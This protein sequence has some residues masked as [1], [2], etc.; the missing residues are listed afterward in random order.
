MLQMVLRLT[1][2]F[3]VV[4]LATSIS[5]HQAGATGLSPQ[6]RSELYDTVERMCKDA[7]SISEY[8]TY[9]GSAGVGVIFKA[10]GGNLS[11]EIEEKK[12]K[13]IEQQFQEFRTNPVVCRFEM[14]EQLTPLFGGDRSDQS[15]IRRDYDFYISETDFL[16]YA[17]PKGIVSA[18]TSGPR[19]S[20]DAYGTYVRLCNISTE[21]LHNVDFEIHFQRGLQYN[22]P[23]NGLSDLNEDEFQY[24]LMTRGS[25]GDASSDLISC[26]RS[27]NICG[28][29]LN[30]IDLPPQSFLGVAVFTGERPREVRVIGVDGR[31]SNHR[32]DI[33]LQEPRH[34]LK[35]D[36]ET[37]PIS[38]GRLASAPSPIQRKIYC[39]C[40]HFNVI[41]EECF[42]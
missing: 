26:R 40:Q 39:T 15:E 17:A 9:K 23:V 8:F 5:L 4:A 11:G 16:Y 29:S 21:A 36:G 18:A 37:T 22:E 34:R 27:D 3:S 28:I 10:L 32:N 6:E 2:S 12:Y 30:L 35:I 33:Y 42:M 13:N 19:Q 20:H 1:R 41:P 31:S 7:S 14:L 38:V 24:A 25:R